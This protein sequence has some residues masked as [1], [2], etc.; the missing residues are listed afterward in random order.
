MNLN[1][2]CKNTTQQAQSECYV[3]EIVL[4]GETMQSLVDLQAISL[5]SN[6]IQNFPN[7]LLQLKALVLLDLADNCLLTLPPEINKLSK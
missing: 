3:E 2:L 1:G 6:N 4:P 7:S 5:R